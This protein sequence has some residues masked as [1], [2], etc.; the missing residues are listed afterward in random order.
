MNQLL[1]TTRLDLRPVQT[2]D[3]E[4]VHELWTNSDVRHFLFDDRV[5]PL[6]E[7]RSLV[8]QSVR[9]FQERGY[10]IWLVFS[11]ETERLIGF[12]G[13][14]QS[15][16]ESPNLIY[17]VHPDFCGQGFAT[18]AAKAA[19]DYA[20][21][22]L[23]LDSIKA[24]VDEPNVISVRILEKLGMRQTRRAIVAGR[25]LLYYERINASLPH[26]HQTNH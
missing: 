20:F 15:S 2:E 13:L 24:D 11:S 16:D 7:A 10:G 6:D 9:S 4:L 8:E 26:H 22:T 1:T 21:Q 19:L 3:V 5:I 14:L 12:A 17:G 18:E 25:P 23:A